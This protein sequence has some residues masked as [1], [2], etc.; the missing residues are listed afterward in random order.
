MHQLRRGLFFNHSWL[1]SSGGS[2]FGQNIFTEGII[3]WSGFSSSHHAVIVSPIMPPLLEI[4]PPKP[5]GFINKP[6]VVW[7]WQTVIYRFSSLETAT[8]PYFF[9]L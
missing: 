8:H 4:P 5:L 2:G 9:T 6:A 3:N 7:K 1:S